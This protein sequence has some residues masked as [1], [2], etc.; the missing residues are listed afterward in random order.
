MLFGLILVHACVFA[1]TQKF[2]V[3]GNVRDADD[4]EDLIGVSIAVVQAG[5]LGTATNSYGFYSISLPEGRYTL[6]ISYIGYAAQEIEVDLTADTKLNVALKADV[7]QLQEV[8]VSAQSRNVNVSNPAMSIDRI[9]AATI[10]K[11]PVTAGDS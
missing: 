11:I 5:N 8:V 1:Q 7:Q 10:K 2:T 3:S 6:K 9:S 4:G